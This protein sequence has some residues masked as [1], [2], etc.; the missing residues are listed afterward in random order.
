MPLVLAKIA[1]TPLLLAMCTFVARRWGESAGG[2]LL[3]LPLTSG[4][5][6]VF[7]FAQYG[8]SFAEK[9]ARS[10]LLG[11]VAGAAFCTCYALVAS[12]MRWWQS[13]GVAYAVCLAIAWVLSLAQLS[14]AQSLP[15]VIGA[16]ALLALVMGAVP[17]EGRSSAGDCDTGGDVPARPGRVVGLLV[18]ML[19]AT[20]SV[21]VVTT[22]AGLLG[23]GVGGLLA[24]LPVLVAVMATS[25]HRR[26]AK[27]EARGLLRGAVV[28]AWGGVAFFAAVA[29]LLPTTGPLVTYGI[30][31]TSAL[32]AGA[33]AM[34]VHER[35]G[36]WRAVKGLVV[37]S[38]RLA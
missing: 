37:R 21:V 1:F 36:A 6:S 33:V 25:S 32:V 30:A 7:L 38:T 14:L 13:L 29:V 17:D 20:A 5:V 15:F 34:G 11:L 27:S 19:V 22:V 10:T 24:P 35:D 2:W 12:R 18:R 9:A 3:G 26:G 23:P 8:S 16:L 4:P 31:T 28:G